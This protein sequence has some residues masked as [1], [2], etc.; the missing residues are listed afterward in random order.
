MFRGRILVTNTLSN[1]DNKINIQN[2][3]DDWRGKW[4]CSA[5]ACTHTWTNTCMQTC[6]CMITRVSGSPLSHPFPSYSCYSHSPTSHHQLSSSPT[7]LS[8]LCSTLAAMCTRPA[9]VGA[10]VGTVQ[11]CRVLGS[12]RVHNAPHEMYTLTPICYA[13]TES[14]SIAIMCIQWSHSQ[15]T[16]SLASLLFLP[17]APWQMCLIRTRLMS[18]F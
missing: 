4:C 12:G 8:L 5:T 9:R 2:A 10:T 14:F 3:V 13:K 6:P 7:P 1:E 16:I 11:P 17:I 18:D 15:E